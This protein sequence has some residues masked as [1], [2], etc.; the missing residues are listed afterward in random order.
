MR[1]GIG[2]YEKIYYVGWGD[3]CDENRLQLYLYGLIVLVIELLY[4]VYLTLT[5]IRK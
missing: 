5:Q 4:R 3:F 1:D 2:L